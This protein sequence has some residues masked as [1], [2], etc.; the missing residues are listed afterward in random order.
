MP[1]VLF[2]TA[3]SAEAEGAGNDDD[4]DDDD[5]DDVPLAAKKSQEKQK[6][7]TSVLKKNYCTVRHQHSRL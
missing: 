3:V 2:Q 5:D 1:L 4:D 6:K 7:V